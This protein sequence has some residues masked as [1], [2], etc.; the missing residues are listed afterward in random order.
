MSMER[1]VLRHCGAKC[2]GTCKWFTRI[3]EDTDCGSPHNVE[4]HYGGDVWY[5]SV[6]PREDDV[7]DY[8]EERDGNKELI[9]KWLELQNG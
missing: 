2:C 6:N 3:Y 4:K 1:L 5:S 7:C 8:Y 9:D